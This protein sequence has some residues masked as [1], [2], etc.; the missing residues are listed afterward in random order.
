MHKKIIKQKT[1]KKTIKQKTHKKNHKTENPQ[2]RDNVKKSYYRGKG[3]RKDNIFT[4][5]LTNLRGFKSKETSLRRL[6]DKIQPSLIAMNETLLDGNMKVSIPTYTTWSKNRTEKG[7]GGIATAV[8]SRFK[9]CTV[10]AGQ[11]EDEDEYLV[12]RLECFSPALNVINC[13]GEQ[14]SMRKEDIERKWER[15]RKE[16]ENIR[17]RKEFVCLSGDLNKHI[18]T[19]PLGVPGNHAEVSLGGRLLRELLA[20]GNWVLINGLGQETVQGGPFTRKDPATGSQSCLDLF[21]VSRELRPYVQGLVIDSKR[22]LAVGRAVKVGNIYQTIYSDH[23]TCIL[24][25]ENL[26]TVKKGKQ[27]KTM[28]WNLAKEGGWAIYKQLTEKY[29]MAMDKAIDCG[30]NI[31]E[32]MRK[33]NKIH[34]KIKFKA[35][36]KITVGRKQKESKRKSQ[37]KDPKE[38]EARAIFE[39]EVERTTKEINEI[40]KLRTSKVGR[41]W[42]IKKRIV[43]GRK[44]TIEATAIANP[45]MASL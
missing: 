34:E 25:F 5:L 23:Y 1:H 2:T 29:A 16:M 43:G 12:T 27:E 30:I 22:E 8:A 11:G 44:A 40:K 39:E 19:G 18:G 33:F 20:T 10:G 3:K 9:D 38:D 32:K 21:I 4:V 45:K 15:L 7:G 42:D 31:E 14:R 41:I 6:I 28:I 37:N 13:Y 35:F 17:I 26:P 36:G 24:T